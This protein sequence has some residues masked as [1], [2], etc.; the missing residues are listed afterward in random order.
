MEIIFYFPV[1]K[2]TSKKNKELMLQGKIMH[3]KRPDID[4]CIKSVTDALNNIAYKDDGQI[5]AITA[6]KC[7]DGEPRTEVMIES[8]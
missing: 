6:V 7:Y 3:T 4:N 5:C 1:P 8:I 2:S